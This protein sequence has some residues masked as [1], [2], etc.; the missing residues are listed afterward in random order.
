MWDFKLLI[1]VIKLTH[2]TKPKTA[3]IRSSYFCCS[4]YYHY[5]FKLAD[6]RQTIHKTGEISRCCRGILGL[7]VPR[8]QKWDVPRGTALIWIKASRN[9]SL[10]I[11]RAPPCSGRSCPW[12]WSWCPGGPWQRV[13][14]AGPGILTGWTGAASCTQHREHLLSNHNQGHHPQQPGA[15]VPTQTLQNPFSG[16]F[17]TVHGSWEPPW[18]PVPVPKISLFVRNSF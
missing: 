10:H 12:G 7:E 9:K 5:V 14:A 4:F 16:H 2:Y 8:K 11:E 1:L 3:I 13:W 15:K 17:N 6:E 18:R